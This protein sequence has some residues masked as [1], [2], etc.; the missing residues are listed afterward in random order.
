MTGVYNVSLP[1]QA[2]LDIDGREVTTYKNKNTDLL[3]VGGLVSIPK[4]N[5]ESEG[6]KLGVIDD[7]DIPYCSTRAELIPA[8]PARTLKNDESLC[9]QTNEGRWALVQVAFPRS[10]QLLKLRVGFLK[11]S[12]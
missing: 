11:E 6:V 3:H 7:L 8:I 10:T 1:Q 12:P 9:V 4:P 2:V 5:G